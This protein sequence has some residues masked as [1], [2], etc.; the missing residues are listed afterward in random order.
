MIG[1][2]ASVA[3]AGEVYLNGVRAETLPAMSLENVSVR[4]DAQGNVWIIA[5]MYR[6]S[7]APPPPVATPVFPSYTPPP[8]AYTTSPG[9]APV[10]VSPAAPAPKPSPTLGGLKAGRWWLVTE[11][12]DSRGQDID[13]L[14][15]GVSVRHVRSGESQVIVDVGA[16]LRSGA[17]TITLRAAAGTYAGGALVIYVGQGSESGG[18]VR[19]DTPDVRYSRRAIDLGSGGERSFT[20]TLP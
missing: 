19:M 10:P 13:V 15:N 14:V 1:L 6:M 18:T 17:N 12:N 7:V 9:Y 3:L 5:P 16:W 11:D 4:F 20:L 2:L 8:P